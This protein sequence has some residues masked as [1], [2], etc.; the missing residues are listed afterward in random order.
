MK[1]IRFVSLV[2]AIAAVVALT[3]V[4]IAQSKKSQ[5][6]KGASKTVTGCLQKGDE[7]DEYSITDAHGKT[8]GLR[9]SSVKLG[10]HLGHKVTVTGHLRPESEENEANERKERNEQNEK[11]EA[12][13][14][15]VTTLKMVSTSCQ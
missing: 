14:I 3:S 6:A 7:P 9:S 10:D 4:A 12:G 5:G 1:S 8:Y 13:D 15:R 11:K 2:L